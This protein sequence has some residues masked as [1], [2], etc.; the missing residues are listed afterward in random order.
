MNV[1]STPHYDSYRSGNANDVSTPTRGGAVLMGGGTDVQDAFSWMVD[2]SGGG[3]FLVLRA[4]G[5]DGYNDFVTKSG[6]VNS[7]ESV[8]FKDREASYQTAI[9]DKIDHAEAVFLAGG[10]QSKYVSYWRGTP[11]EAALDRAIERGVPIGG[12]SAGL[13]VLGDQIFAAGGS[14]IS[15]HSAL[16]NPFD[17]RIDVEPGMVHLPY[18]QGVLTDTHFSQRDRMGRL[19]TFL[20]RATGSEHGLGVDERTAVLVDPD[21]EGRVVGENHA[22]FISPSHPPEVCQPGVPLVEDGINVQQLKAGDHFDFHAWK[23]DGGD[24]YQLSAAAGNVA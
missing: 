13:A 24:Q 5:A 10:D 4:S 18:M 23:G 21:G 11:V 12:T 3:D 15:S 1:I 2:R 17:S 19:V 16:S 6:P 7:V 14:G 22:Y 8:V 20:A 9:V